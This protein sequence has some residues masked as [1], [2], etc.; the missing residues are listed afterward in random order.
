MQRR[1]QLNKLKE[2]LNVRDRKESKFLSNFI[3]KNCFISFH[4]EHYIP[5]LNERKRF[6]NAILNGYDSISI[7]VSFAIASKNNAP[8]KYSYIF[9]L[10]DIEAIGVE[11]G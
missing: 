11:E 4:G 3:G 5:L 1:K 6:I 8:K 9:E 2:F 10:D 7:Y